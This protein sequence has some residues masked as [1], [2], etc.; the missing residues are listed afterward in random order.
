MAI[1]E[2]ERIQYRLA[3]Q[4]IQSREEILR[5]LIR[6]DEG[7]E[8]KQFAKT[9]QQYYIGEQD[10]LKHDFR[11]AVIYDEDEREVRITN[12]NNSNHHNVHNFYA[13]QA[14][15]KTAYIAGRAPSI[16]VEG[17]KESTELKAFEDEI[18]KVTSD[19]VFSDKLTDYLTT[20][21]N[22]G[23]SWLHMFYGKAGKLHYVLVPEI[24][25]IPFYDAENQ[26]T[27]TELIR[28]Y[29]MELPREGKLTLRKKAQWWTAYGVTYYE[30]ND[31]GDF[32][33]DD[34]VKQNPSAHWQDVTVT[35]GAVTAKAPRSWGRV[36]FIPLLNNSEKMSDLKRIKG[37]QDAYNLISSATTNNQID[38]VE[39]YW[40]VQGYGAESAKAIQ[41]KLRMNKA[42]HIDDPDGKINAEQVSLGV[43]ERIAWLELLRKDMYHIG[44]AVD[45]DADKFGSAPSG[46]SLKF[47]YTLLDMKANKQILKL[48]V[49]MKDFMWFVVEDINRRDKKTYDSALVRF[50]INKSVPINDSETVQIIAQSQGLVPD[51]I[52]LAKHPLVDDVNQAQADMEAQRANAAKRQK[53]AFLIDDESPGGEDA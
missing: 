1:T 45:T 7:S 53:E 13:L 36:P 6:E 32:V 44:M 33:L 48:G 22:H 47:Q 14:D 43:Q 12:A 46:V 41:S 38:L 40:L 39:L 8:E 9:A 26:D 3:E 17:A 52:L 27:L 31:S 49:A 11:D 2:M 20:A 29:S 10:I 35:D 16:S 23:R 4:G 24:E 42:V 34:S 18:T 37:L 15:Q 5:E 51:T 50:D 28:Y 21:T 25:I 19:E 30:E